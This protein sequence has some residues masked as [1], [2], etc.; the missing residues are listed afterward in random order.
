M[1][2][3]INTS[4]LR[5]KIRQLENKQRHAIS[6]Y[7]KQVRQYNAAMKKAVS[8]YNAAVRQYNSVVRKNRQ[9][10][11]SN[12][13]KLN[14]TRIILLKFFPSLFLWKGR[15]Q[16]MKAVKPEKKRISYSLAI[17]S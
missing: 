12:I 7:N 15:K 10:I 11:Q 16:R 8:N 13:S 17:I 4:Q 6:N 5:S 3:R 14:C 1:A 2:K 9:I